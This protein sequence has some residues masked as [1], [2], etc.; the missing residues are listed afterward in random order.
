MLLFVDTTN[1]SVISEDDRR[2]RELEELPIPQAQQEDPPAQ[3][4]NHTKQEALIVAPQANL[5][6]E[7]VKELVKQAVANVTSFLEKEMKGHDD[8]GR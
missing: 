6:Q 2:R 4:N 8:E 1:S 3:D 5:T 7:V